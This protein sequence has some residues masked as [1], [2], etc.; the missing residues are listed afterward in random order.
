[1]LVW[2]WG[3]TS[4]QHSCALLQPLLSLFLF[5]VKYIGHQ[6][7]GILKTLSVHLWFADTFHKN[8]K[9]TAQATMDWI[10]DKANSAA[11][12]GKESE[13]NEDQLDKG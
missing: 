5:S 1:M 7:T 9:H 4:H 8:T 2:W 3:T 10:K 12:G 13:K 11:G 6:H